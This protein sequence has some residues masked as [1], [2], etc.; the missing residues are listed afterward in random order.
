[1]LS[2]EAVIFGF[3]CLGGLGGGAKSV[4]VC[5]RCNPGTCF[6]KSEVGSGSKVF[7]RGSEVASALDFIFVKEFE[8]ATGKAPDFSG[9]FAEGSFEGAKGDFFL[10]EHSL[11]VE[12]SFSPSF[13][14][15]SSITSDFTSDLESLKE[16]GILSPLLIRAVNFLNPLETINQQ[17]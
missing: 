12:G 5:A 13:D 4:K 16:S 3:K 2:P 17:N 8:R 6:G 7:F 9:A 15:S 1:M 11:A 10:N 14:L